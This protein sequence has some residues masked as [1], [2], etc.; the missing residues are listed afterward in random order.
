MQ[1]ADIQSPSNILSVALATAGEGGEYF[2][3]C[4]QEMK[5]C[6]NDASA[7]VFE[8]LA[9]SERARRKMLLNWVDA[10]GVAAVE[11]ASPLDWQDPNV[12]DTYDA[13][14]VD[15]IRSTPYRVLAMFAHRADSSFRFY[16]YVA[17]YSTDAG[18]REYAEILAEEELERGSLA[19]KQRRAAWHAEKAQFPGRPELRSDTVGSLADLV[20]ISTSLERCV[21]AGLSNLATHNPALKPVALA[22]TEA[23]NDIKFLA[24]AAGP[25]SELAAVEAGAID[26]F[27][28]GHRQ[29][30]SDPSS[31][32]LRLYSDLDRCF[33]YYDALVN[34]TDD[35]AIMLQA[36]QFA[37][38]AMARIDLL[39]EAVLE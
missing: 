32:L 22:C 6:G 18:V 26:E 12:R 33:V 19:R 17:A 38:S 13:A 35:E 16:S 37:Y 3:Q 15:P 29:A 7:A 30:S 4:Q 21:G 10:E 14:A 36:Q 23:I 11:S 2:A 1:I 8:T 25:P 27:F 39:H 9:D 24:R 34:Y 28:D 5:Q 20:C 31:L